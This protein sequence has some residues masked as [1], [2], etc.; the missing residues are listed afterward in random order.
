MSHSPSRSR[1]RLWRWLTLAGLLAYLTTS[2]LAYSRTAAHPALRPGRAVPPVTVS[3]PDGASA[4]LD[5]LTAG[6]S[7]L[8]VVA[9][10]CD[11]CAAEMQAILAGWRGEAG[12][13]RDDPPPEEMLF[14]V[15]RVEAI[16]RA[17]F[18]EAWRELLGT[19]ACL[20]L[21]PLEEGRL[22]GITRVPVVVR[23]DAGGM[24]S[25]LTYLQEAQAP[26]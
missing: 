9:P 24:V 10:T 1:L 17:A 5:S 26:E 15:L 22:L 11:I 3:T 25:S 23:L 19:P 16:P 20:A 2:A 18:M 4:R 13:G 14:L 7:R 12:A 6:R 8:L 21:I